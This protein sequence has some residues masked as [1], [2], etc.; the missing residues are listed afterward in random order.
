VPGLRGSQTSSVVTPQRVTC[1]GPGRT[2]TAARA[3]SARRTGLHSG[4]PCRAP[5]SVVPRAGARPDPG[6]A[7]LR[8]RAQLEDGAGQRRRIA[9]RRQQAGP[10]VLDHLGVAAHARGDDGQ[11]AGHGLQGVSETPSERRA[12]R[13]GW[14]GPAGPARREPRPQA[15]PLPRP[16][17]PI[18]RSRAARQGPSPATSRRKARVAPGRPGPRPSR[19]FRCLSQGS[20]GHG[21]HRAARPRSPVGERALSM[22]F[23]MARTFP[24]RDPSS[25][26]AGRCPAR[27]TRAVDQP[28]GQAGQGPLPPG[29]P[30]AP[31]VP[32][33]DHALH[34]DQ[35]GGQRR[36]DQRLLVVGVDHVHA[37]A[38]EEPRSCRTIRGRSPGGCSRA[39]TGQPHASTS[40]ARRPRVLS[41]TKRR[42]K[43]SRSA[44]R[45]NS[46]SSFSCP[47]HVQAER[48]V[49]DAQPA[50]PRT[51]GEPGRGTALHEACGSR[52][53]G[54]SSTSRDAGSGATSG[55]GA[56]EA[57]EGGTGSTC[58]PGLA[59]GGPTAAL[60]REPAVKVAP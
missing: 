26:L 35:A 47:P 58:E 45:A 20:P 2:G 42:S 24:G 1:T 30:A 33:V 7:R 14:P 27:R 39:V 10:A 23:Q 41:D 49:S 37:P 43:R 11:A 21:D 3:C 50:R 51:S 5:R 52:V 4:P 17:S 53:R 56:D 8:G 59:R 15:H 32:G 46:T 25:R 12:G 48:D 29:D 55:P 16:R 60:S 57:L 18:T 6:A 54:L 19:D 36:V 34:A 9:G 28:G 31:T 22:P 13:R 44:Y 40:P 38:P